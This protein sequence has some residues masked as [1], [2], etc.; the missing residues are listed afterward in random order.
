MI[1]INPLQV[2]SV[3]FPLRNNDDTV[4]HSSGTGIGSLAPN[5]ASPNVN[6]SLS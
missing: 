3:K 1:I 4:G 2:I 6:L 5:Y